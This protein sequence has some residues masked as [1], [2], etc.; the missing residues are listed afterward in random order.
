[1]QVSRIVEL[2]TRR[3]QPPG[4]TLLHIYLIISTYT[5][6]FCV[7]ELPSCSAI[8]YK[9]CSTH[10][11]LSRSSRLPAT[12]LAGAVWV[13]AQLAISQSTTSQKM[14]LNL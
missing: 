5:F 4:D 2:H 11:I 14:Q 6:P 13:I 12:W 9:P 3:D 8:A 1:M 7:P 10:S